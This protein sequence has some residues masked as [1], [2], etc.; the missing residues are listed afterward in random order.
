MVNIV[1]V[2]KGGLVMNDHVNEEGYIDL[3][4]Y[5]DRLCRSFV[6][7]YRWILVLMIGLAVCF[8]VYTHLTCTT[9]YSATM[10]VIVAG[11]NQSLLET[12]EASQAVTEAFQKALSSEMMANIIC[13]DLN[14][15]SLPAR[16]QISRIPDTNLMT[17][18]TTAADGQ[19]AY[20]VL[21]SVATH[22]GQLTKLMNSDATMII[23]EEPELPTHPDGTPDYVQKALT[24]AGIGVMIGLVMIVLHAFLR[25]TI[26]REA[27]LKQQLRLNLLGSVPWI[28][29]KKASH[30]TK[31][32]Y[33]V[34]NT[35]LPAAFRESFN[36]LRLS[37]EKEKETNGRQIFMFTSAL[38]NEGKSTICVN[39]AIS[40]A[41]AGKK[42]LLMDFDLRN[43]SVVK[44]LQ[45]R[46]YQGEIGAFL[47][48]KLYLYE[49]LK[50][51]PNIEHLDLMAGTVSYDHS[52]E[53]LSHEG[54]ETIMSKLRSHYD[55]ILLD[56]PPLDTMQDAI[57]AGRLCDT[58]ILVVR[59]DYARIS[60][61]YD[62][63]EELQE[64][65]QNIMGCVLNQV[66]SS[67]FNPEGQAYGYGYGYGYGRKN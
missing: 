20:D 38:P 50:K 41:K 56:V 24:G 35:R 64:S 28:S 25:K 54:L 27:Q 9:V 11:Q 67:V 37:M 51:H 52:V 66:K 32:N 45:L 8:V 21:H 14:V 13:T 55:Y 36:L 26:N 1:I 58:A 6:K 61:I 33:L 40:L 42:V 44:L 65:C 15:S 60:E 29:K 3:S 62:G 46:H 49:V 43:P 47:E 2:I 22:Y 30:Q 53:L 57:L 63:L 48:G 16:M 31:P 12:N 19:T 23:V 7:L 34:T 18:Q 5:L 39:A 59:Q 4:Q 17:I 10:T